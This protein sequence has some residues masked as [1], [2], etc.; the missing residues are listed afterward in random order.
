[1]VLRQKGRKLKANEKTKNEQQKTNNKKRTT[2]NEQQKTNN[3]KRTTKNEQ[4]KTNNKKQ[5]FHP[6][7]FTFHL[8]RLK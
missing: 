1:M 2:K 6:S 8:V 3:K 4:Q 5:S 7:L